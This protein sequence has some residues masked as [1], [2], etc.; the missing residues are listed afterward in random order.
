MAT[1]CSR[2]RGDRLR[3][4]AGGHRSGHGLSDAR[5]WHIAVPGA[6]LRRRGDRG[7]GG[8][9]SCPIE[10]RGEPRHR[11]TRR[12]IRVGAADEDLHHIGANGASGEPLIE[13]GHESCDIVLRT[14]TRAPPCETAEPLAHMDRVARDPT[15][16]EP[17]IVEE[18]KARGD[19]CQ[20]G[21][22]IITRPDDLTAGRN[23]PRE[24]ETIAGELRRAQGRQA[25][26]P[27]CAGSQGLPTHTI[28]LHQIGRE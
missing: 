22:R 8:S 7:R 27:H 20:D 17:G 21:D 19:R 4:T 13:Q 15:V 3:D 11:G 23:L 5:G 12:R 1:P 26:M 14:A 6:T 25:G 10:H 24:R 16:R 2:S 9:A 18:S 28:S